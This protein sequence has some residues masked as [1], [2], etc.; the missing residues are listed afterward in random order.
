MFFLKKQQFGMSFL[1]G[2]KIPLI[3][4][5]IFNRSYELPDDVVY[6]R[7][8]LKFYYIRTYKYMKNNKKIQIL[9]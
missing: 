5:N 7:F 8:T 2:I 9:I 6:I 4:I 3:L 1:F